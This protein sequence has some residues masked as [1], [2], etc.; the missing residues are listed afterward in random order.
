M[1]G[2]GGSFHY[3]QCGRCRC[4]QI[5]QVPEDLGRFYPSD[6]YSFSLDPVPLRGFKAWRHGR[7]DLWMLTGKGWLSRRMARPR[8]P[9]ADLASLRRVG[10]TPDLR[11]LDIGCGRGELLSILWRAGFRRLAGVDPYL[12]ADVPLTDSLS[13]RCCSLE[14]LDEEFD[15]IMMHHV[16]EHLPDPRQSLVACRERLTSGGRLLLRIPTVDSEAWER[17]RENWVDLDA[18]RHLHLHSRQSLEILA[19]ESGFCIRDWWCDSDG[20]QIWGSELYRR[21]LTLKNPQG[22]YVRPND[23]FNGDD[24]G[25]FEREA[26]AWNDIGRGDQVAILLSPASA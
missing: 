5:A 23:Y 16:F 3:F 21:G 10:V 12:T 18:P 4:L 6:Y 20:F 17:Y 13:V 9:R 26:A 15:L 25:R 2:F 24:L 22:A 8:P 19:S 7:R 14:K 1:F 11:V